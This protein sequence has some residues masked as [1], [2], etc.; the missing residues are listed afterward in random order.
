MNEYEFTVIFYRHCGEGWGWMGD[1]NAGKRKKLPPKNYPQK[2]TPKKQQTS[3][4]LI[5]ESIKKDPGITKAR[6]ADAA[7][8]SVEGVRYHIRKM[9]DEGIIRYVGTSKN[10]YWEVLRG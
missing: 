10:G 2:T 9:T 3:R 5:L 8:I 7:N 4:A 1:Q 6:L